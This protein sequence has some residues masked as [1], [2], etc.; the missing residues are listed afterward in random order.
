MKINRLKFSILF[1]LFFFACSAGK[2]ETVSGDSAGKE[3][4]NYSFVSGGNLQITANCFLYHRFDETKYPSTSIS[5]SL[6]ENHLKYLLDNDIPVITLGKL[7]SDNP[8]D[9]QADR[10]VVLTIDDAFNSFYR[11][12]FPIL[13]KYGLK[14]TLF[15]NTETIGS[16]DYLDWDELKE[17]L[18]YGIELGNHTHTHEYF[19]NLPEKERGDIF[20]NDVKMAQ[21]LFKNRFNY[22]CTVFAYPF[23][24]YDSAMKEVIRE[25]GFQGAAA[26]N[27]GV[28]SEFSDPFALP[29]FPM[30]DQYGQLASFIE[31]V[32]MNALPV[33]EIIPASSIPEINPPS[34]KIRLNDLGFDFER[35]QC[36]IQGG[37][38]QLSVTNQEQVVIEIKAKNELTGR[39][40]LYTLTI[41]QT[42]TSKWYWFS[43]QWVF[44]DIP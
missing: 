15:V 30:T 32:N 14:A 2:N 3:L 23:G 28:I 17:L 5:S 13:K 6:F 4:K 44:P 7:F 29:R 9:Y 37:E 26:Q 11:Y 25:L 31:K 35:L 20:R 34:L 39:R 22:N 10:F 1:L 21:D 43:H 16:G 40:H 12:G 24:E 38:C 42:G 8:G 27:S 36:F 41:P 33:V 19:L 18:D